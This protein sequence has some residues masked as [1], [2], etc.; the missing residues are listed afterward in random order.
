MQRQ[1]LSKSV[2]FKVKELVEEY[3]QVIELVVQQ[4]CS[5]WTVY[6]WLSAERVQH[7]IHIPCVRANIAVL[8]VG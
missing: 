5:R 6:I 1:Q 2:K 3:Y 4:F 8:Y 7:N